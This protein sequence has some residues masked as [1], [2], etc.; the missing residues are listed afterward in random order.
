[1]D[2]YRIIQ[3]GPNPEWSLVREGRNVMETFEVSRHSTKELAEAAKAEIERRQAE[4][5]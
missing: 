5:T 4:A 1:M 3:A 2:T